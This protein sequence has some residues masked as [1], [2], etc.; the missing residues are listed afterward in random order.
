MSGNALWV[1]VL[2]LGVLCVDSAALRQQAL[3]PDQPAALTVDADNGDTLGQGG[4]DKSA[5]TVDH[6]DKTIKKSMLDERQYRMVELD[7]GL[8]AF[9]VSDPSAPKSAAS[10]DVGNGYFSDPADTPGLAH[11]LEHML[12]LGTKKYPSESEYEDFLGKHGGEFNAYTSQ[13]NTNFFFDVQPK[14]FEDTL[15][16]FAQ[17]FISPMLTE[18]AT[19]REMKAVNAEHSKNL[20]NDGWR[21]EQ[22]KQALSNEKMP[23]HKF[24]TGSL[25]TLNAVPHAE[26]RK[27]LVKDWTEHFVAENLKLC[28][29]DKA[30]LDDMEKAVREKFAG[31]PAV[32]KKMERTFSQTDYKT[33]YSEDVLKSKVY[34]EPVEDSRSLA[35]Y[36]TVPPQAQDYKSRS[37]DYIEQIFGSTSTGSLLDILKTQ[38]LVT[39]V[40]VGQDTDADNFGMFVASFSLTPA[41]L[42]KVDYITTVFYRYLDLV[43]KSGV[44]EWRYKELQTLSQMGFDHKS[45][46]D[47]IDYVETLSSKMRY[48]P[49]EMILTAGHLMESFD[50]KGIHKLLDLL[51][52]ERM[53]TFI[54]AK[55]VGKEQKLDQMEKWYQI[56]Y[57]RAKIPEKTLHMYKHGNAEVNAL[58]MKL[59]EANPFLPKNMAIKSAH[60]WPSGDT[61]VHPLIIHEQAEPYTSRLWF[62]QDNTFNRPHATMQ[63]RLWSPLPHA[64]PRAVVLTA[65][66]IRL[67]GDALEPL[68]YLPAMAGFSYSLKLTR[69][70]LDIGFSGYNDGLHAYAIRT[71]KYMREGFEQ[72]FSE[73]RFQI[74][75]HKMQEGYANDRFTKPVSWAS[76]VFGLIQSPDSIQFQSRALAKVL[77]EATLDKVVLHAKT[78]WTDMQAEGFAHGNILPSEA[79]KMFHEINTA[80]GF[81]TVSTSIAESDRKLNLPLAR[82]TQLNTDEQMVVSTQMPNDDEPNSAVLHY[83]QVKTG[84]GTERDNFYAS[85]L[86]QVVEKPIYEQMR[87]AEQLGYIVW[88][89]D[90]TEDYVQGFAIEIQSA[91][92]TASYVGS[93]IDEF[94][95]KLRKHVMKLSAE[96]F[97]GFVDYMVHMNEQPYTTLEDQTSACWGEIVS[98]QLRFERKQEAVKLLQDKTQINQEGFN[99]FFD[100]I[101]QF[102]GEHGDR[103]AKS[104]QIHI[105]SGAKHA[106][107]K[108]E[109]KDVAAT[110][111]AA[112]GKKTK[113]E[114]KNE[115]DSL[116]PIPDMPALVVT[117]RCGDDSDFKEIEEVHVTLD[118]M[119][120][121]TNRLMEFPSVPFSDVPEV[122]DF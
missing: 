88:S 24:G 51:T 85:I 15:D 10:M 1:V 35:L 33:L 102:N 99:K 49:K 3:E 75:K 56:P 68:D 29:L 78:L 34:F 64:T 16:R 19:G 114:K 43:K 38:G 25:E 119:Y 50:A 20:Q 52:P 23:F 81:K 106:E 90:Y 26:M 9:L 120:K 91:T 48:Y 65:L 32:G 73:E 87:T 30:P 96:D 45:K 12:F 98:G 62:M 18:S 92:K 84:Q 13:E 104:I 66:W 83:Y 112:H 63:I 41:G 40:S 53:F 47:A 95:P 93:R 107:K 116:A 4:A 94:L 6:G 101:F 60:T 46:E 59:P 77:A 118:S 121:I 69:R 105:M 61:P 74:L 2:A 11:F 37:A 103:A 58:T 115:E 108:G 122:V 113:V 42:K 36:W 27:R 17:F 31:V 89:S 111:I 28:I 109:A 5:S 86:S 117:K 82:I 55:G 54:V 70:G 8:Q 21:F 80:L 72:P 71:A 39:D 100:N 79:T 76:E 110:L 97:N 57:G 44:E 22:V 67:F 14:Y 7:N